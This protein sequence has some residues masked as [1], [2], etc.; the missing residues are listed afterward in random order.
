MSEKEA[1]TSL[2]N[3]LY[4]ILSDSYEQHKS[5]MSQLKT[6]KDPKKRRALEILKEENKIKYESYRPI[7]E[8]LLKC[9]TQQD[10]I[11]IRNKLRDL[12]LQA[13]KR[14]D[15]LASEHR[16]LK[17]KNSSISELNKKASD[18]RVVVAKHKELNNMVRQFN[19]ALEKIKTESKTQKPIN[20]EL[21]TEVEP[22]KTSETAKPQ[23]TPKKENPTV[24]NKTAA[25]YMQDP[26]MKG[27]VLLNERIKS[28][29][30][31]YYEIPDK[32]SKEAIDM[33]KEIYML[34]TKRE[35]MIVDKIGPSAI[36]LLG[37]IESMEEVTYSK[38]DFKPKPPYE[39]TTD[40]YVQTLT[41]RLKLLNDLQFYAEDSEL[42]KEAMKGKETQGYHTFK[43]YYDQIIREYNNLTMS[44]F[45]NDPEMMAMS[46]DLI[47]TFRM[48]NMRG[49]FGQF[50]RHHE[51][52]MVAG[53]RVS[54]ELYK[55]GID[56][57]NALISK[58]TEY[59]TKKINSS[60][61]VITITNFEKTRKEKEELLDERYLEVYARIS[62]VL[63]GE[64]KI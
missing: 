38:A 16:S 37:E 15:T 35:E 57:I 64:H 52:G 21:P 30:R 40:K 48:Y 28:A 10:L 33:R 49:G 51:D 23:I 27:F 1:I 8:F 45:G 53:E 43:R 6:E 19:T 63:K 62:Q 42:Y 9:K 46:V 4:K 20:K 29:K 25:S 47:N 18:M 50:K 2:Q 11:T 60:G 14:Y 39:L 41:S 17:E 3:E 5:Y 36:T 58:I 12:I 44:L 7:Y 54:K 24:I 34:C 13:R 56:R 59:A 61:G 26:N 31:R 55:E 32:D 22:K